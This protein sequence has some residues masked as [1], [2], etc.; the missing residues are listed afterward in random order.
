MEKP[1]IKK[2][3]RLAALSLLVVSV[4]LLTACNSDP[5]KQNYLQEVQQRGYL[6][7]GTIMNS[8][9][10]HLDGESPTG[11]E[12]EMALSLADELGVELRVLDE[13]QIEH[14]FEHLEHGRVD[15][16]AAGL[17]VTDQRRK[18]MR[19]TPY[20]HRVDQRLIFKQGTRQ[21]PRDW[22]DLEGEL[23]VV[24]G[25]SHEEYL[26]DVQAEYPDLQW[27][28][29]RL[30]DADELLA[31]VISEEIDFT[32][33]DTNTLDIK[34][35][36]YPDLSVAFTVRFD[37]PLAW[38]FPLAE[39]DSLYAAAIEYI[40]RQHERGEITKLVDRYWG[41]VQHFNYVD[42]Q[43]FIQAVDETLPQYIEL[44][45][46][47]AGNLDWRL[48][49]AISYQESL[50]D[51]WARSP[52]GV[53]GM[54]MLTLPTARSMG[55]RSRLDA[56]Q[57]IRGGAR[58]LERLH[59]RLPDRITEPDRTW[60]ALAA[61]N[62]GL[63]HLNDAREITARQGGD[64]DYWVDVRARLPLLRQKQY[65][66]DTR[67]GFARGDEPVTYVGNIRRYYDTLQWLDSQNRIPYPGDNR[68][69]QH[70][71]QADESEE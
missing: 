22:S 58:Y 18:H 43:L 42:T 21:R 29:T 39:D 33:A 65:Y 23:V 24:S 10:Y 37:V 14:L 19:F 60:F 54:M 3:L 45:Q 6:T 50:W 46:Q 64:A 52:T 51:P 17:D 70:E 57:A 25:S 69:V 44:F 16:L 2:S 67:Y 49:A 35:R 8:S 7:V 71:D 1:N 5:V 62:V 53:R 68:L 47:Y 32:I 63:G 31:K 26:Q 28:A 48:L 11:F 13:V 9:S 56:E 55:V 41:H 20:Y 4:S 27:R 34:R 12:Y 40:G 66:K 15:F 61:Y 30:Y 36:L 38:A 59:Q